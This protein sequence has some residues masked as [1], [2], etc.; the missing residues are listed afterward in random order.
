M[1][2]PLGLRNMSSVGRQ[3]SQIEEPGTRGQER[4]RCLFFFLYYSPEMKP[5][6]HFTGLG[7]HMNTSLQF[8]Q[9]TQ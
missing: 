3:I 1:A 4:M 9:Y 7:K 6:E 5:S 8:A 2:S